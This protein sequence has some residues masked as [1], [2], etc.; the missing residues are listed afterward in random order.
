QYRFRGDDRAGPLF[1]R[2]N[3]V[4]V[5][6]LVTVHE[7]HKGSC[8]EQ[9]FSGHGATGGSGT[10]DGAG[11]SRVGRWQRCREDRVHVP[12]AAFPGGC[13]GIVPE[14]RVPLPNA[15][16]LAVWLSVLIWWRDPPTIAWLIGVPYKQISFVLQCNAINCKCLTQLDGTSSRLA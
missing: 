12:W 5:Q 15:C 16:V 2:R 7:R 9:E 6:F 3:A 14:P 4:I 8:I 10:R 1:Q 11:P 13:P